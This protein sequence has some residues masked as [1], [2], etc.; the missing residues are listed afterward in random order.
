MLDALK[1]VDGILLIVHWEEKQTIL[2]VPGSNEAQRFPKK[3]TQSR[4]CKHNEGKNVLKHV[5]IISTYNSSYTNLQVDQ[6]R[7]CSMDS[8]ANVYWQLPG[9][10][11][12][13]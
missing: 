8:F 13:T 5:F 2:L 12:S 1:A 7:S 6:G 3:T 10:G 4:P 11:F 9:K